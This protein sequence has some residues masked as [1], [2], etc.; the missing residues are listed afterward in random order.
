MFIYQKTVDRSTLRQ[1][2]QIPV[3][4]HPLLAAMPGGMPVHGETRN[5]S[6]IID[7]VEYA[8]QLKNQGFDRE[9]YDGHTDVIQIRYNE[10]SPIAKKLRTIFYSTWDYVE[11]E[12]SLPGNI[13]RRYT[14]KI[15]KER[16]EYLAISCS[17]IAN[18]FIADCI[19]SSFM[20]DAIMDLSSIEELD[21][22]TFQPREDSSAKI[23]EKE[24]I[25]KVRHPDRSIGDSLKRLYDFQWECEDYRASHWSES[26]I[27]E[28]HNKLTNSKEAYLFIRKVD[29]EHGIQMPFIYVGTG[30]MSNPVNT[31]KN[32]PCS[33]VIYKIK[34][35]SPLPD[36][37][38]YDFEL[39][40]NLL[41]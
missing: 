10:N 35:D 17:D 7:G 3:E 16:Q 1:G 37:L 19:T 24:R 41:S 12:K 30:K 2:F 36:D 31:D 8:A 22:E 6:I 25:Q 28:E 34:M 38:Q 9:K 18:I 4:F 33:T 29:N 20:S 13:G 11:T 32:D 40:R 5:I 23:I 27:L 26:K 14:I 39:S 15:P 21:F